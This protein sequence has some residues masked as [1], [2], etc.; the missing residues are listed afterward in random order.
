[1]KKSELPNKSDKKKLIEAAWKKE[2]ES[3]VN[4]FSK[5]KI[6]TISYS[7]IKKGNKLKFNF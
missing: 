4:A 3:R 6:K 2:V 5:G 1:M 7:K